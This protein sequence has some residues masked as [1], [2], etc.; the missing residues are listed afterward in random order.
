MRLKSAL[1]LFAG[2]IIGCGEE[3]RKPLEVITFEAEAPA[4]SNAPLAVVYD[5]GYMIECGSYYFVHDESRECVDILIDEIPEIRQLW[6]N[7]GCD[8]VIDSWMLWAYSERAGSYV[9]AAES[10][11]ARA[12][13][14]GAY[15]R[16]LENIGQEAVEQKWKEWL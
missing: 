1:P 16:I 15:F 11:P 12:L 10:R 4:C 6:Q 7:P 9:F 5:T 14:T 3:P 13:E 2:I 8:S